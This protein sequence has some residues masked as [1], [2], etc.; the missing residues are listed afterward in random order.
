VLLHEEIGDFLPEQPRVLLATWKLVK[1]P[2]EVGGGSGPGATPDI[3]PVVKV[4]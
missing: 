4:A 3:T 2:V 1:K